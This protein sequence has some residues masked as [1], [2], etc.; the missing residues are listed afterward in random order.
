MAARQKLLYVVPHCPS[1]DAHQAGQK[2]A[3]QFLVELS[4]MYDVDLVILCKSNELLLCQ[5]T[6]PALKAHARHIVVISISP[7]GRILGMIFGLLFGLPPRLSTRV[8]PS[9]I[10]KIRQLI[11]VEKKYD[12][13]WLEFSQAF[14]VTKLAKANTEVVLSAHDIQTQLVASKTLIEQLVFLG[15]TFYTEKLLFSYAS[16]VRVQS[17]N[18]K[19]LLHTLFKVPLEKIELAEPVISSFV[20]S[21]L[22]SVEKVEPHSLLFWGA[23]GREENST[24]I[25]DFVRSQFVVLKKSYPA[26]KL[27]IIGS[28]P[29][30]EVRSLAND[31]IVVTGFV[32]DPTKYF[33]LASVGIAPLIMGAGIKVKVLEMLRAGIPVVSTPVGAEGISNSD[34]M[35]VVPIGSFQDAIIS[36]WSRHY[37]L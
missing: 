36:S 26:A 20:T 6:Y 3:F 9:V 19:W 24:A 4:K 2:T 12:L 7:V 16:R 14:W 21:V 23:M 18:D 32:D 17:L 28:N 10:F 35:T 22:R 8:S 29:P 27:Y 37:Q 30:N 25:V 15:F 31:S 33:E 5:E 34:L 1:P 11:T 13:L